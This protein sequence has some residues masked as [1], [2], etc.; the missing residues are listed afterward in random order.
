MIDLKT[1]GH[2]SLSRKENLESKSVCACRLSLE[3]KKET[4]RITQRAV[5]E[6]E[7]LAGDNETEIID[8]KE[9]F[10]SDEQEDE[11]ADTSIILDPASLTSTLKRSGKG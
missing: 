9:L 7:V 2:L 1:I 10:E 11:F 5:R 6:L 4:R 3:I 8:L